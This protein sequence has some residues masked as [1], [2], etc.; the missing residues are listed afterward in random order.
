MVEHQSCAG[1]VNASALHYMEQ[2]VNNGDSLNIIAEISDEL[3][4]ERQKNAE[5]LERISVLEA[6]IKERDMNSLV[7]DGNVRLLP[8]SYF[9]FCISFFFLLF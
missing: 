8:T 6:Q 1:L 4:R 5:L 2:E 7:P 3:Q 9:C